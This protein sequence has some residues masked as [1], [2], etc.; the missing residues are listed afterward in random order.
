MLI[1]G[2]LHKVQGEILW[3]HCKFLPKYLD[4]AVLWLA[5]LLL[6]HIS[7]LGPLA[8]VP[9]SIDI[10]ATRLEDALFLHLRP[11]VIPDMLFFQWAQCPGLMRQLKY[12]IKSF[13]MPWS[14][15]LLGLLVK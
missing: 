5:T 8:R 11:F 15:K 14:S 3:I 7:N 4:D 9:A 6:I 12:P 2:R 13:I 10:K 1:E